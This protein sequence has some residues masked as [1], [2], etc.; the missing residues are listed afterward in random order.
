MQTE[1]LI[2]EYYRNLGEEHLSRLSENA[3]LER[4]EKG[5]LLLEEGSVQTQ[6]PILVSGMFRGYV[7]DQEGRDVTDWFAYHR[8]SPLIGCYC[9]GERSHV[10]IEALSHAECLL[11]PVGKSDRVMQ[12]V[13]SIANNF[14]FM[15]FLPLFAFCPLFVLLAYKQY[16]SHSLT[17]FRFF[18]LFTQLPP[19]AAERDRRH[20]EEGRNI[21]V[22]HRVDQP[23]IAEHMA[24][25]QYLLRGLF[26]LRADGADHAVLGVE[27]DVFVDRIALIAGDELRDVA[28]Q[29]TLHGKSHPFFR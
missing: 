1:R 3:K 7:L 21:L 12:S 23:R 13:S 24:R 25:V 26:Q 2:W 28:D 11:V 29:K 17:E 6:L 19:Q 22:V 5:E 15:S 4:Y 20:A 18:L 9:I 14:F 10:N 27:V 8:G 16:S